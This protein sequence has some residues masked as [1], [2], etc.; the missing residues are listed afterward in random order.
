MRKKMYAKPANAVIT[1]RL[2]MVPA[3][4]RLDMGAA[5]S[6]NSK[7]G[8]RSCAGSSTASINMPP[9][10]VAAAQALEPRECAG[11]RQRA[12]QARQRLA[13]GLGDEGTQESL[14]RFRLWTKRPSR[15]S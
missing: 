2:S 11:D 15:Q 1:N 3:K 9:S 13:E 6:G 8:R 7:P 4:R 14:H 10:A 12:R 5:C